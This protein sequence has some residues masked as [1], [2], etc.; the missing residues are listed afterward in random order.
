MMI[1]MKPKIINFPKKK[2][3]CG[4]SKP[5]NW[6]VQLLVPVTW[7]QSTEMEIF[8]SATKF[9]SSLF[10]FHFFIKVLLK[11]LFFVLIDMEELTF[12][13]R[14]NNIINGALINEWNY[15]DDDYKIKEKVIS[16]GK[17]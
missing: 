10:L 13:L 15:H 12:E 8:S 6:P 1:M 3:S 9:Y 7:F 17:I 16:R 11:V 5:T 14:Q 2:V 4:K